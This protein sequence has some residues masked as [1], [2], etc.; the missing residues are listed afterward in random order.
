MIIIII[1]NT[2]NNE[3]A[4]CFPE[5]MLGACYRQFLGCEEALKA[6]AYK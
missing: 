2:N 4:T 5:P 3:E 6:L 1:N